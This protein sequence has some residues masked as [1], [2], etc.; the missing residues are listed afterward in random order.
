MDFPEKFETMVGERGITLSGGQKQR[1]SIARA[2]IKQPQLLIFDDCLSAVDTETEEEILTNLKEIMKNK[3]SIIISHRVSSVKNADS[4]IVLDQGEIV[5]LGHHDDLMAKQG[6][7]F[8]LYKMQLL[9]D[10]IV[11]S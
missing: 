3:T 2:I 6:V 11:T 4:I 9:E 1:I 10:E 5:E 7:Y 8:E